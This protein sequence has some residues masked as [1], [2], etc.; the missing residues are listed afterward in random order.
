MGRTLCAEPQCLYKGVPYL[1]ILPN[2]NSV[3]VCVCVSVCVCVCVCVSVSSEVYVSHALY[4]TTILSG[5]EA[6]KA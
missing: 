1:T 4:I 5:E 3:C 6:E 2:L